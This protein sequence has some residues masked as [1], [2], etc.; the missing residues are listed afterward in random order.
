M[1]QTWDFEGYWNVVLGANRSAA[2][3]VRDFDLD[4]SDE[5]GLD[6]WLGHSEEAALGEA[7]Q[8]D[9]P[10]TWEAFHA[11]ALDALRAVPPTE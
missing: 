9:I 11:R 5:R 10:E 3:V 8:T 7:R 2:D 6:E 1:A 4:P